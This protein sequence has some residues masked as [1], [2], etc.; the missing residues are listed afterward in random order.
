MVQTVFVGQARVS[1]SNWIA[2]VEA[3]AHR[4]GIERDVTQGALPRPVRGPGVGCQGGAAK[5]VTPRPPLVISVAAARGLGF[6]ECRGLDLSFPV[7]LELPVRVA[8]L[9]VSSPAPCSS[10]SACES[11]TGF[12]VKS[13]GSRFQLLWGP[14]AGCQGPAATGVDPRPLLVVSVAAARCCVR[15]KERLLR[16]RVRISDDPCPWE[17]EK[18]WVRMVHPGRPLVSV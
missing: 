14:R 2:E 11:W 15:V 7:A 12:G 18:E 4:G 1:F 16:F 5:G 3:G 8:P 17:G 6:Q 9:K 13:L 10:L